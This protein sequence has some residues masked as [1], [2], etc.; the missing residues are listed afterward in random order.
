MLKASREGIDHPVVRAQPN[1]S[2]L[3]SI[4]T[5]MRKQGVSAAR[6]QTPF[7]TNGMAMTSRTEQ[8]EGGIALFRAVGA[9]ELAARSRFM[10]FILTAAAGQPLT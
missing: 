4:V 9:M 1:Q 6:I 7:S 2:E 10:G 3:R 8:C 5:I